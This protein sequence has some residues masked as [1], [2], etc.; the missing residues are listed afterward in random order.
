MYPYDYVQL[1]ISDFPYKCLFLFF[2]AYKNRKEKLSE[3]RFLKSYAFKDLLI[4]PYC[5]AFLQSITFLDLL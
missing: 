4:S 2:V 5:T 3:S 1:A